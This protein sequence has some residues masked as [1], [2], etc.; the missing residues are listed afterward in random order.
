MMF[1]WT[2]KQPGIQKFW[3]LCGLFQDI[4]DWISPL[5]KHVACSDMQLRIF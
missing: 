4:Y 1:N 2:N 5:N 3:N